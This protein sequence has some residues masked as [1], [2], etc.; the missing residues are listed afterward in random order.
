MTLKPMDF[1]CQMHSD[2]ITHSQLDI[3]VLVAA[4][5]G[6]HRPGVWTQDCWQSQASLEE[7]RLD[8]WLRSDDPHHAVIGWQ[9]R[10]GNKW[11]N[12]QTDTS[13]QLPWLHMSR[14]FLC[15][16]YFATYQ[17]EHM[18]TCELYCGN[19]FSFWPIRSLFNRHHHNMSG[20]DGRMVSAS[21]SQP[22]DRGFESCQKPVGSSKLSRVGC[23]WRHWCLGSLSRKWVPGYRQR[24]QLYLDYPWHLERVIGCILPGELSRWRIEQVCQ[25]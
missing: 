5:W 12:R 1:L 3:L 2:R 23:G 14:I 10:K 7:R 17:L 18:E 15:V 11:T 6:L 4:I 8:W 13:F 9:R 16:V 25:G 20:C 19:Y 21:D 22:Q 24:W